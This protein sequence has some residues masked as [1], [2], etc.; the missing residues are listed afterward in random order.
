L[1][2]IIEEKKK[3]EDRVYIRPEVTWPK[4]HSLAFRRAGGEDY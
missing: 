4:A 3:K 2:L 1:Q